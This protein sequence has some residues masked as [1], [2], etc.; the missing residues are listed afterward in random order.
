MR[1]AVL[2]GNF[3]GFDFFDGTNTDT[4]ADNTLRSYTFTGLA[5]ETSYTLSV[6]TYVGC[7]VTALGG[8][9]SLYSNGT[10]SVTAY[11]GKAP[12]FHFKKLN[13]TALLTDLRTRIVHGFLKSNNF[14]FVFS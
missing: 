11:T 14:Q 10:E 12:P 1:K 2:L 8:A 3:D 13:R 4:Q 5:A 7:T 6:K 9:V